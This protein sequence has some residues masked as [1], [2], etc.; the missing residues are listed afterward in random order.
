LVDDNATSIQFLREE[1]SGWHPHISTAAS[2]A[3]AWQILEMNLVQRPIDIALIDMN[4]PQVTGEH[5]AERIR[6]D[7]RMHSIKLALLTSATEQLSTAR[8]QELD[9]TCQLAKPVRTAELSNYLA[10]CLGL[11]APAQTDTPLSGKKQ[12]TFHGARVLL[13]EDNPVNTIVAT[14]MLEQLGCLVH[15][16]VDGVAAVETVARTTFDFVFMDCMMPR[17][18]GYTATAHIRQQQADAG[19]TATPIIALTANVLPGDREKCLAAG[20][21]DYLAKPF[22]LDE[23]A[24][25][26]ARWRT[27]STT[28]LTPTVNRA[29]SSASAPESASSA[30]DA[31]ILKTLASMD[32]DGTKGLI[33][34]VMSV[35]LEDTTVL[36]ERMECALR[37]HNYEALRQAAHA[38]KSCSATIGAMG[39]SSLCRDLEQASRNQQTAD[40]ESL[41]TRLRTAHDQAA[42]EAREL[43]GIAV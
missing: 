40:A 39:L 28:T 16:A 4:M 21:S 7:V 11:L 10:Q 42:A 2:A 15:S 22:N 1:L 8:V 14:E 24:T 17:M 5:L 33:H 41:L 37:E 31:Y 18:D 36:R 34:R 29:N 35:F 25:T 23:L 3:E 20:M 30:L 19:I 32:A 13:V 26:M 6:G 27:P 9:I 12:L 43:G 38:M